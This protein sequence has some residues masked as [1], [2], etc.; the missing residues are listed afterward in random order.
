[1]SL[2][3]HVICSFIMSNWATIAACLDSNLASHRRNSLPFVMA[4]TELLI[5]IGEI[6]HDDQKKDLAEAIVESKWEF[7]GWK[8]ALAG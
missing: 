7:V 8:L 3:V 2:R 6:L 1:M 4:Q 5:V